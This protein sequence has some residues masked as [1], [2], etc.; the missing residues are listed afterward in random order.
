VQGD[1]TAEE[2]LRKIGT[3]HELT[4]YEVDTID[5][6][7]RPNLW[8]QLVSRDFRFDPERHFP[9]EK[10]HLTLGVLDLQ[11]QILAAN[12]QRREVQKGGK[13]WK[14]NMGNEKPSGAVPEKRT[15]PEGFCYFSSAEYILSICLKQF[16]FLQWKYNFC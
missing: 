15:D 10:A 13:V 14:R 9:E 8:Q 6:P 16:I 4:S 2:F 1:L 12:D 5:L 7:D 3:T 11:W